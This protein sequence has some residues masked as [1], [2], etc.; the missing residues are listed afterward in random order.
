MSNNIELIKCFRKGDENKELRITK[1]LIGELSFPFATMWSNDISDTT[2]YIFNIFEFDSKKI[3]LD[4]FE[5]LF[6]ITSNYD[7]KKFTKLIKPENFDYS[8]F[9]D[10]INK[11]INFNIK[12]EHDA[13]ITEY[14]KTRYFSMIDN[15]SEK[16][17]Y[18][19]K[20]NLEKTIEDIQVNRKNKNITA[21]ILLKNIL[22]SYIVNPKGSIFSIFKLFFI[23]F[24][25]IQFTR[26][27][28]CFSVKGNEKNIIEKYSNGQDGVVIE[29]NLKNK[30]IIEKI[31][32]VN[33]RVL[34]LRSVLIYDTKSSHELLNSKS[35]LGI[36]IHDSSILKNIEDIEYRIN[37]NLSNEIKENVDSIFN[38]YGLFKYVKINEILR[39]GR[40]YYKDIIN[41]IRVL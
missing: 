20:Q 24:I 25:K 40:P 2:Y 3:M 38:E 37:I 12:D 7:G 5:I 26:G 8:Y 29:F 13:K 30:K 36:N 34:T 21:I 10:F 32:Y 17:Y 1:A 28:Y 14:L 16:Q 22:K 4:Y 39:Y 19:I 31:R 27:V 35:K 23:E 6:G 41:N 33:R 15:I 9:I 11:G 18:N